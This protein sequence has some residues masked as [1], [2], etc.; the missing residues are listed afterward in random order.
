MIS[1]LRNFNV[2]L[3]LPALIFVLSACVANKN[4]ESALKLSFGAK[5]SKEMNAAEM[6]TLINGPQEKLASALKTRPGLVN[7]RIGGILPDPPLFIALKKID[8]LKVQ[9]LLEAGANPEAWSQDEEV[10]RR[11]LRWAVEKYVDLRAGFLKKNSP[12][13]EKEML[14]CIALLLDFGANPN[15]RDDPHD[16]YTPLLVAVGGGEGVAEL[17]QL[18]IEHGA[19]KMIRTRGVV[20]KTAY[21]LA[22]TEL[23]EMEYELSEEADRLKELDSNNDDFSDLESAIA[24]KSRI[25]FEQRALIKTLEYYE[26]I[27]LE[28]SIS[29]KRESISEQRRIVKLLES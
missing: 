4:N 18:L 15:S 16:S 23:V 22:R 17:V 6:E 28:F 11:P 20:G 7:V 9:G 13:S 19:D 1:D 14:R 26:L 29:K 21:E 2:I 12:A 5:A 10:R 8:A 27:N 24:Q 3:L 25:V